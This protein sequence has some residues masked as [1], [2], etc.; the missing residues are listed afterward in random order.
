MDGIGSSSTGHSERHSDLTVP[1]HVCAHCAANICSESK[2][3]EIS[4][5]TIKNVHHAKT[6]SS[7]SSLYLTSDT[8]N[9]P[10]YLITVK[11]IIAVSLLQCIANAGVVANICAFYLP[12]QAHY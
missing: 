4:L 3:C 5:T 1:A 12:T 7:Q 9:N 8:D 6:T 10:G 11:H 2:C